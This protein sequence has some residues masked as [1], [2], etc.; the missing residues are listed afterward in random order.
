MR[1]K[2]YKLPAIVWLKVT[3]F[4]HGWL[5]HELGGACR[6]KDQKV[7]CV[8]GLDGARDVLRMETEKD[9]MEP[10][11]VGISM[12]DTWK[13]C[14]EVGLAMDAAETEKMYGITADQMR[15]FVP[16]ECPKRCMTK[17]GVLRTWTLCTNFSRQQAFALQ[18]ILREAFWKAV[19]D[20]NEDYAGKMGGREY[21][22]VSMIEAFCE[23]TGTP[24]IH[25]EAMR[26]EW[27]R[28]VRR[29]GPCPQT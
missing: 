2:H 22:A 5:Q 9:L 6:V 19:G 4:M 13:N 27:Q 16:V 21:P 15:M 26:R 7:I 25:V 29:E 18:R 12:S 14:I 10:K 17:N 1:E 11:L 3:D 20:F 24:D 28:R 23:E 8:S